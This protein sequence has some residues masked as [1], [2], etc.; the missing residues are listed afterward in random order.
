[1]LV[2][3]YNAI[4]FSRPSATSYTSSGAW[5]C[6]DTPALPD[7]NTNGACGS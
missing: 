7:H 5:T 2:M 1:M 4:P 6:L 3:N